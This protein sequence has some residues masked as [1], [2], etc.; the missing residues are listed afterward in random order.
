MKIIH[1]ADLHIGSK[2]DRLPSTLKE[3]LDTKLRNAF[4]YIIDYAKDNN[5]NTILMCGD[6]FDKNAVLIK[7][8]KYF[9]D[10]ISLNS[11]IDFYYIKGNHDCSS[12]YNENYPNLH[13]FN[14]V[15]TYSKDDVRIIGYELQDDNSS[16]YNYP[17]FT[18]D[19][20]NIMMLHGDI[21]NSNDR[22]YIN[23]KKL[24]D[25]NISYFALGHIHKRSEGQ[26]SL[27]KYVYPGSVLGRGFDEVGKKGF[28]V[29]DTTLKTTSFIEVPSYE[30]EIIE[31]NVNNQ[32]EA[33]LKSK[34]SYC[35]GETN[36]NKITEIKFSGKSDF[37]IDVDEFK[38]TFNDKRK[39]LEIKNNA[40][41]KLT[42]ETNAEE[43]SLRNMFINKVLENK[44]LDEETRE[45]VINYGLS[46]LMKEEG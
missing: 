4:R 1:F 40:K 41:L 2:F 33:E 9:Y 23:L 11:Q 31:L 45:L 32:N 29:L 22:N 43:N 17:S 44:D 25:M 10:L 35:L 24:D 8:K 46:K 18:K 38:T 15:E 13:T 20:F 16:L 12:K 30:F 7:D 3:E 19:K 28:V 26:S 27:S 6:I 36:L 37:E 21:F 39:Y 5:I 34:I 42:Y 14:G